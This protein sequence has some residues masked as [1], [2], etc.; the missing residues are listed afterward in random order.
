MIEKST[1]KKHFSKKKIILL[2]IFLPIMLLCAI[3]AFWVIHLKSTTHLNKEL[4]NSFTSPISIYDNNGQKLT[5]SISGSPY[6]KIDNLH[7][8]T[9]SSFID[10]EDKN[11]Y[12]HNGLN[13][14]RIIKAFFTNLMSGDIEQGASTITQQL[15]KNTHL[16]NEKTYERK[17]KEAILALQLEKEYSK[18]EILEMYLNAIYFG[19]G[20]Y[21]IESASNFYFNKK[22]SDLTINESAILAGIIKSPAN[23][24]PITN[25]EN[26]KNRK[27]L[28]LNEMLNDGDINQKEYEENINKDIE[29]NLSYSSEFNKQ[30]YYSNAISEASDI[31]N[32]SPTV[33]SSLGYKIFTYFDSDANKI[34]ETYSATNTNAL[35]NSIIVDNE[36]YGVIAYSSSILYG[37]LAIRRS[38][39]STIKPFLVYAPACEQGIIQPCSL[40]LDEKTTFGG[41][42]SPKNINDLYYGNISASKALAKSLNVPA[43]KILEQLGI[44]KAKAYA[45]KLNIPF[46]EKDNGLS[47][48]LGSMYKGITISELVSAYSPFVCNGA[49]NKLSFIKEIKDKNGNTIYSRQLTNKKA[50]SKETSYLVGSM[51]KESVTNGTCK[52]LS[53]FNFEIHAKSGTNGTEFADKNT[54]SLC[55]AQTT[56]HTTCVW[57][58]SKDYNK[59][60]LLE[61]AS[62]SGLSPTLRIKSIFEELY[63]N[64]TPSNFEK[65]ENVES[66]LLDLLD[67]QNGQIT[68]ASVKAPD[69]Y[70]FTADFNKKFKPTTCS[71]NFSFF[72]IPII[73]ST[74]NNCNIC[75]TFLQEL[76]QKY[77][78]IIEEYDNNYN[79]INYTNIDTEKTKDKMYKYEF[80][81]NQN[82]T[83][84]VYVNSAFLEDNNYTSSNILEIDPTSY[85]K[86]NWFY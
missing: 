17:I 63:K 43:V 71:N 65:P 59:E 55:V 13:L 52:A 34:L 20:C 40:I 47:L 8:Y 67:Y 23:Y 35:H 15:I 12:T 18:D 83:Y 5:E 28:I 58:Y 74:S 56:K 66:V 44:P 21:G 37:S 86:T 7:K 1:N 54:D 79:L 72:T 2:C 36:S 48:A 9:L 61:N 53:N 69:K 11:F 84:K 30:S 10:I 57:Y 77:E 50:F 80:T 41:G 45:S 68:L 29:L 39:A 42:Y 19:N 75:I 62:I 49:F 4:L 16:T 38:P 78:I 33:L 46:T 85:N 70:K 25:K 81:A 27:N 24:C 31:L 60:N 14:P 6:I 73:S 51:M 82:S 64:S 32:V 3:T 26:I 76:S 22:A